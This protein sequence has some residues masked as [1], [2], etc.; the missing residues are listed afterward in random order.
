MTRVAASSR[1]NR[2]LTARQ[3][4]LLTVKYRAEKEWHPATAMDLSGTGCR[5][6]LG[7]DLTRGA[8]VGV[9]FEMPVKDGSKALYAEV[10]GSVIWSRLEGLSYQ[11][12]IQ[13]NSEAHALEEILA[14]IR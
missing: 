3:A 14:S 11:A 7:Q 9:T 5:L 10:T 6:R 2:R 4:C 12:G 1:N 8:A 13:F